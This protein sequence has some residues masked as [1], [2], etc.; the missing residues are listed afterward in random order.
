MALG[1]AIV[2]ATLAVVTHTA[3]SSTALPL[4]GSNPLLAQ[5]LPAPP[6]GCIVSP[7]DMLGW[8]PGEGD[9]TGAIGPTLT[10]SV[11]YAP[12]EVGNGIVFNGSGG[13]VTD[14]LPVVDQAVS[15][16][17]WIR[18]QASGLVQAIF[19][20]FT[21]PGG[22]S[23][24]SY[25]LMLSPTGGLWW[26]TDDP[27]T[28]FPIPVEG[29]FPQL[30]DGQFHHVAAT[31]DSATTVLYVD[32]TQVSTTRS[33]GSSVNPAPTTQFA[34]GG[35]TGTGSPMPFVGLIDEATVYRR[36]L[37]PAE[38][39]AIHDAGS[40]GKC[41]P[42]PPS[43]T[44]TEVVASTSVA[45]DALG[46]SVAVSGNTMVVGSPGGTRSATG[47]G[48]VTVFVRNGSA[49]AQEAEL[50]ATDAL[51]GAQFGQ[52]VSL[53]GDTLVIGAPLD[54]PTPSTFQGGS[55]YVFTRSG[56]TWSQQA[57]LIS[58][59]PTLQ[60]NFA[61]SV[62]VNGDT[63]VIGAARNERA[64]YVFTRTGTTW[65]Q[66]SKLAPDVADADVQFATSVAI[67]GDTVAVGAVDL[68][69]TGTPKGSAYVFSRTGT[70]WSKQ[71]KL[72][73]AAQQ[74][75][76]RFGFS[77]ALEGGLLLVGAPFTDAPAVDSGEVYA[78]GRSGST[79]SA[80]GTL[81]PT[82]PTAGT[83]FG[84]AVALYLGT[85]LVGAPL[86]DS[87]GRDSGAAYLFS[88]GTPTWTQ[89]AK[90]VAPAPAVNDQFG[91]SLAVNGVTAAAGA[92]GRDTSGS[93]SGAA[94]TFGLF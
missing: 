35:A 72:A 57:K 45:G 90:L 21:W 30:F 65:S 47:Q 49:W 66:Q 78:F 86:D 13:V 38:V 42:Q 12:A 23:E 62:A 93:D 44:P 74:L 3:S 88:S 80:N 76:D 64:A 40:A 68:A 94:F 1:L 5:A 17:A 16:D 10:G 39:S 75:G 73:P 52:S 46:W 26:A 2:I 28:L 15:V 43:G 84:T 60:G 20:R 48:V 53:S 58:P 79:W 56:T 91:F 61:N 24:D 11:S 55:A 77:V 34:L 89:F 37:T 63:T 70:A 85:A 33:L 71:A 87:G 9:L 27:S 92:P 69:A 50:V 41:P 4:S 25:L 82:D 14:Q 83:R 29:Q 36:A 6:T 67:K 22:G 54:R 7:A 81:T 32:G 59:H 19:S 51:A 31:W 8:W 18:P